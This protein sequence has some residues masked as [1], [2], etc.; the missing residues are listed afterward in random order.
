MPKTKAGLLIVDDEPLIRDSLSQILTE[1]GYDARS[2]AD[3]LSAL[4]EIHR[5]APKVLVSDLNMPGM[6]GF[7]LLR[8]VRRR[9]PRI[10]L[11]AMSGAFSGDE[12]PSGVSGD[13]FYQKG[14]GPL[15]LMGI[16]ESL[17]C[18]EHAAPKPSAGR[19]P[20]WISRS[21]HNASGEAYV[22]IE[23]QECLGTFPQVLKGAMNSTCETDCVYCGSIIRY[24]IT[25]PEDQAPSTPLRHRRPLL[26][27]RFEL[28]GN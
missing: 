9:F 16:I 21:R 15:H 24:A 8:M 12:V 7:E 25:R 1:Y 5:E 13:A 28:R 27:P 14:G 11:I 26:R 23:C 10:H 18:Q 17:T 6:S 22:T 3:G 2:A 19:P 20:V 4:H